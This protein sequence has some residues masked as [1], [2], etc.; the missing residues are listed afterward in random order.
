MS[1]QDILV[2]TWLIQGGKSPL[3]LWPSLNRKIPVT[4]IPNEDGY[5]HAEVATSKDRNT[6]RWSAIIYFGDL[7][8][9][10]FEDE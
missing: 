2:D 6:G 1:R 8:E 10:E 5:E 3:P 4:Y 9:L 7:S